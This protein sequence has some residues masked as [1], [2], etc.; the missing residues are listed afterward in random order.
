MLAR[1]G[2]FYWTR[3]F[4]WTF[5]CWGEGGFIKFKDRH[6]SASY[7]NVVIDKELNEMVTMD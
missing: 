2:S 6:T 7:A 1:I 5:N 4:S 3:L